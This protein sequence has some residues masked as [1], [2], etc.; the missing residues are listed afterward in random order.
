[1]AEPDDTALILHTS[2][3]TARPKIVPLS[4]ANVVASAR[5]IT[6]SLE[7]GPGDLCLN[8]MPLFHIH[9]LIAALLASLAAGG[10]VCC[11]PGLNAFRFFSWLADVRPTWFTAVPTMHQ[12]L[13]E[14]APRFRDRLADHRLR[15]IR[16]SS[17]SLPPTVM[18]DLET[19]FG[20]PVIEAY[21]MTEAAHQM[22]ANPLP[23]RR[24]IAGSV[25]V[26][27]GP[28]IA[29]MDEF[30][31]K[32]PAGSI[33]EVVVRGPNVIRGYENNPDA[34]AVS[35]HGDWFR[36]GDQGVLDGDG[37]LRLTGRLKEVINRAGEK[38]SP[39]EVEAVLLEHPAVQQAAVFAMA[40]R[41]MGES[42]AAAV[43]RRDGQRVEEAELRAFV[44]TRM[45]AF[46]VPTRIV[47]LTELPKGPTG[48]IQRIG[49]AKRIGLEA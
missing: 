46:K 38:V 17:A 41:L 25:G 43:V 29:V 37:Y 12:T 4:H 44:A 22:A 14:L 31:G 39:L 48:K 19:A 49:M 15:F 3:T 30:G 11:T 40:D 21:G 10:A 34:N 13:L 6:A 9:G 42:V 33:G 18:T 2:G 28:E 27:A 47:I 24:R 32:L 7:L 1:M 5:H 26:A 23:P 8:V 35:F 16:S 20:V 36:T 45:T